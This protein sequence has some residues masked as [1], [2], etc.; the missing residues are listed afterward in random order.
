M[1]VC[2]C[3]HLASRLYSLPLHSFCD[4][5]PCK[6]GCRMGR[7]IHRG[8][9]EPVRLPRGRTRGARGGLEDLPGTRV[10]GEEEAL[11]SQRRVSVQCFG[12]C[13]PRDQVRQR[14]DSVSRLKKKKNHT[15]SRGAYDFSGESRDCDCRILHS[16]FLPFMPQGV[17]HGMVWY[18]CS[19]H[20]HK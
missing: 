20:L 12:A 4:R 6:H 3:A 5:L 17:W 8:V 13:W 15:S 9:D 10:Q 1:C 2:A 7:Q 14:C 18:V 19:S 11:P 16:S